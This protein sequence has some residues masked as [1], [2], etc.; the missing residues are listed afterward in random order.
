MW[1]ASIGVAVALAFSVAGPS[2][3]AEGHWRG[4]LVERGLPACVEEDGSGGLLPCV[5]DPA[6]R[7]N[8]EGGP[9]IVF[10]PPVTEV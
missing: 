8:G 9:V 6:V 3:Q 7:G 10:V 2:E 4:S 5:W 1:V